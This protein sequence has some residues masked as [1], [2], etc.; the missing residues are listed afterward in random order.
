MVRVGTKP[1]A[2]ATAS[3]SARAPAAASST[4]ATPCAG[5]DG[6]PRR[7]AAPSTSSIGVA[8]SA[9]RSATAS[10]PRAGPVGTGR[11]SGRASGSMVSRRI[12]GTLPTAGSLPLAMARPRTPAGRARETNRG[13][14]LEYPDALCELDHRNAFELLAATILSAQTTDVRVNLVTPAL[15]ARYPTP[16]DLAAADPAEVE[17]LIRSTGFYRNKTKSLIGMAAGAGRPL[18]RRGARRRWRDLVTTARAWD[19]RPP[20]WCAAWPSTCPACRSTPTSA[21]CPACSA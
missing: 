20:T 7:P 12:A 21:G 2:R 4:R 17:E 6:R 18:R 13:L 9:T 16:A 1:A 15:F 10:Q 19:A 5:R 8:G 14:A 3:S 11:R